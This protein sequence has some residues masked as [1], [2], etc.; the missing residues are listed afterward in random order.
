[1]FANVANMKWLAMGIQVRKSMNSTEKP[2]KGTP[3][4]FKDMSIP[5]MIGWAIVIPTLFGVLL[6]LVF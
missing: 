4:G 3:P 2:S 6:T 1:M 5:A